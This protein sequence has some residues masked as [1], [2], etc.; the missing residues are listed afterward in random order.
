MMVQAG[1]EPKRVITTSTMADNVI[2]G[3]SNVFYYYFQYLP[4]TLFAFFQGHDARFFHVGCIITFQLMIYDQ[5][6][7]ALGLPAIGT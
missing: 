2:E 3:S 5:I 1:R 4:P 7:Q 6:K